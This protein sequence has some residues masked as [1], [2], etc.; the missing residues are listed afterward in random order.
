MVEE[1]SPADPWADFRPSAPNGV[2]HCRNHPE[3]EVFDRGYCEL[4]DWALQVV[5]AQAT[6][7]L[8]DAPEQTSSRRYFFLCPDKHAFTSRLSGA[9]ALCKRCRDHRVKYSVASMGYEEPWPTLTEVGPQLGFRDEQQRHICSLMVRVDPNALDLRQTHVA[10]VNSFKQKSLQALIQVCQNT[11]GDLDGPGE[12]PTRSGSINQIASRAGSDVVLQELQKISAALEALV[13]IA[14]QR[15]VEICGKTVEGNWSEAPNACSRDSFLGNIASKHGRLREVSVAVEVKGERFHRAEDQQGAYRGLKVNKENHFVLI[16][17]SMCARQRMEILQHLPFHGI[18]ELL[19]SGGRSHHDQKHCRGCDFLGRLCGASRTRSV[20]RTQVCGHEK[21]KLILKGLPYD[22]DAQNWARA[23]DIIRQVEREV[24]RHDSSV[25]LE[26]SEI[27]IRH[28]RQHYQSEAVVHFFQGELP[29]QIIEQAREVMMRELE[30]AELTVR[31]EFEG[32]A[33]GIL[34]VADCHE[35]SPYSLD[36]INRVV[37]QIGS[38]CMGWFSQHDHSEIPRI[39]LISAPH[40][41]QR[42]VSLLPQISWRFY[43][44]T[45]PWEVLRHFDRSF[46]L[47]LPPAWAERLHQAMRLSQPLENLSPAAEVFKNH[48]A[49]L[50]RLGIFPTNVPYHYNQICEELESQWCTLLRHV[51]LFGKP[52][53]ARRESVARQAEAEEASEPSDDS[54][55]E[56]RA[57]SPDPNDAT[58]ANDA[59]D[60]NGPDAAAP[61]SPTAASPQSP[62]ASSSLPAGPSNG[63]PP[64]SRIRCGRACLNFCSTAGESVEGDPLDGYYTDLAIGDW[65]IWKPELDFNPQRDSNG[66]S[67]ATLRGERDQHDR[68]GYVPS[69]FLQPMED[70]RHY[71]GMPLCFEAELV[72]RGF[73]GRPMARGGTSDVYQVALDGGT[74][75]AKL[76]HDRESKALLCAMH[77]TAELFRAEVEAMKRLDHE[78]IASMLDSGVT[79]DGRF[80]IIE[81]FVSVHTLAECLDSNGFY[82]EERMKVALQLA[83]ALTYIHAQGIMHRDV[84]SANVLVD[85]DAA[86]TFTTVKLSDFGLAKG[87][88]EREVGGTRFSSRVCGT[89]GYMDP[90]CLRG[91]GKVCG[92]END[93]YRA[94]RRNQ[95]ISFHCSWPQEPQFCNALKDLASNCVQEF[96]EDRPHMANVQR[97]LQHL[98]RQ[99]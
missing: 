18:V 54:D 33:P 97:T 69:S 36:E 73:E 77:D 57:P 43:R 13:E 48:A 10:L 5:E 74:V 85:V 66:W 37:T 1:A 42:A 46:R 83:D 51:Y 91:E 93:H 67:L 3:E 44:L 80:L 63:P 27:E 87:V 76:L 30:E 65:A 32:Q 45:L 11:I 79:T 2:P 95:T 38:E 71:S 9:D 26:W 84:K 21:S 81:E 99:I 20:V 60:P 94:I 89:T 56:T 28:C 55:D 17:S 61:S 7:I 70:Y 86:G 62:A 98:N 75:A 31:A 34:Y 52:T 35:E 4:C 39:R 59:N 68:R 82:F 50:V 16:V 90:E 29:Y 72:S 88:Q 19:K 41:L 64:T 24:Q 23:A 8:G 96:S 53:S 12:G 22:Q 47:D 58:D 92:P 78:N 6:A 25:A 15:D 49:G 14:Q 40:W